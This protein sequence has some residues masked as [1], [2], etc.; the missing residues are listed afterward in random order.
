MLE[1]SNLECVRGERLIFRNLN[2]A[3]QPGGLLQLTGTNGSGKTS[4]LRIICRLLAPAHG[5]IRWRGENIDSLDEEYSMLLTYVGHKAALK[6]ELS[7]LENLR[8]TNGL[9]GA[10]SD[11]KTLGSALQQLGLGGLGDLPV[12]LLSEGQRRRAAL[13]VLAVSNTRVWLLDEVLASLDR[14]AV[15]L[16]QGLIEAH[17]GKGGFA[18]VSTHQELTLSA[19][20]FQRLDLAS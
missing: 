14:K 3:L 19:S 6:D 11:A 2:F 8:I 7:A 20:S 5:E 13:A 1:A 16:V 4:L 10:T 17:L 15:D 12:R 9:C 18:I